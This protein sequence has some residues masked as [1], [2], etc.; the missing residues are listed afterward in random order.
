MSHPSR[1]WLRSCARWP[2][3]V[4]AQALQKD[5]SPDVIQ[6]NST[7]GTLYRCLL[8]PLR[9]DWPRQFRLTGL[10]LIRVRHINRHAT[11]RSSA[12]SARTG[13]LRHTGRAL[14]HLCDRLAGLGPARSNCSAAAHGCLIPP[15]VSLPIHASLPRGQF[16]PTL[17]TAKC[18]AMAVSHLRFFY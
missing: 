17:M 11:T 8:L 16:H 5:S 18:V 10:F 4:N 12:Q 13:E 9:K 2:R 15:A 6:K 1:A 14:F 7:S 3:G